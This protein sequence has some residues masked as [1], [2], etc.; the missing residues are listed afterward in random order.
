MKTFALVLFLA[1]STLASG[2]AAQ[3]ERADVQHGLGSRLLLETGG[4]L[5]GGVGG[6]IGVGGLTLV[7]LTLVEDEC[8]E[9]CG[10]GNAVISVGAGAIGASLAMP[11]TVYAVGRGLGIEGELWATWL[12]AAAGL[13]VG[14]LSMLL[15]GALDGFEAQHDEEYLFSPAT[16]LTTLIAYPLGAA[17]G[18]ELSAL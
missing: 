17:V 4:G 7:T 18:F 13:A 12:G 3:T 16:I 11:F 1:I 10:L 5:L 15:V 2:A 8:V 14:A 6:F 9:L